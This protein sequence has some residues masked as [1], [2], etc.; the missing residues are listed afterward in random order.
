MLLSFCLAMLTGGDRL[1]N[2]GLAIPLA[3]GDWAIY[4]TLY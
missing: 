4:K 1:M 2:V 3:R